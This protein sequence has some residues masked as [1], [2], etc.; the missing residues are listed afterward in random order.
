VTVEQIQNGKVMSDGGGND[1]GATSLPQARERSAVV[2]RA[3]ANELETLLHTHVVNHLDPAFDLHDW[4]QRV[5]VA[6]GS[7]NRENPSIYE[8]GLEKFNVH[9]YLEYS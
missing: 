2:R 3:A 8:H 6:T 7:E 9:S 5:K 1:A 4:E